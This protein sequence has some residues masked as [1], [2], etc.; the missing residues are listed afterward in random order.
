MPERF[1]AFPPEITKVMRDVF[2]AAWKAIPS[3]SKE[4]EEGRRDMLAATIFEL[5]HAGVTERDELLSK[6][7]QR[8]TPPGG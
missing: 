4:F 5:V 3:Y 8:W 1:D 7:L 6:T 2:D